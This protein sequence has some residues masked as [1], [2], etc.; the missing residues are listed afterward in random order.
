MGSILKFRRPQG[1]GNTPGDLERTIST[2]RTPPQL[3]YTIASR[4]AF[5]SSKQ[6]NEGF[7]NQRAWPRWCRVF[8]QSLSTSIQCRQSSRS[9]RGNPSGISRT[10]SWMDYLTIGPIVDDLAGVASG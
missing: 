8:W 3:P 10:I 1:C 2:S 7:G 4:L 5:L 6:V 9:L